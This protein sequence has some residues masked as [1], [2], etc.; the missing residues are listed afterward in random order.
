MEHKT[1]MSTGLG[2]EARYNHL[3]STL[4]VGFPLKKDFYE[5]RIDS[6]RVD[7]SLSATF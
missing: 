5:R 1:L 2:I 6:T 3:Y 4:S 7:F